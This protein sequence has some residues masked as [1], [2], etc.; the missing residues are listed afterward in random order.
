MASRRCIASNEV[1]IEDSVC[2]SL[3]VVV[4]ESG[5]VKDYYPLEEEQQN[6]E[7]YRGT[8]HINKD[9]NGS[10]RAYREGKLLE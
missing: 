8:I 4:I 10:L 9:V 1:I 7:W 2:L 5:I 3:H 6:T